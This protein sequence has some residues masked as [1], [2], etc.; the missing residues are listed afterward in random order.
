[1]NVRRRATASRARPWIP[2]FAGM[3]GEWGA[4]TLTAFV[5]PAQAGI[6]NH[7][8]RG[9]FCEVSQYGFPPARE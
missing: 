4:L 7:V 8:G 3:T 2:A 6:H 9:A 1:M 5:I